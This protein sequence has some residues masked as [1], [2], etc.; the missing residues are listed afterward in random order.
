MRSRAS[1]ASSTVSRYSAR[2]ACTS[3]RTTSICARARACSISNGIGS[4][5]N[6][7]APAATGS[8]SRAVTSTTRPDTSALTAMMSALTYAF[9]VSS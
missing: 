4:R 1:V 7:G 6:S 5:R 8:L 9:S 3:V 2:S